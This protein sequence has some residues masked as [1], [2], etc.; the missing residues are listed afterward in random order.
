MIPRILAKYA[1]AIFTKYPVVTITGPRQSGKTTLAKATFADRPYANLENPVTRLFAQEDPLAFLNQYP[2]GAV[3]D[4]IQRAPNLLSYIQVIVDER[5][6]N[7]LYV[8]TGSQQ[9]EFMRGI[10][11]SLAG[12]TA[13]LKLLPLSIPELSGRFSPGIDEMLF[14]GFYPRIYDQDIE[15]AQAYGDY[16]ET[17]VERDLRQL[18]NVKDLSVFQ[19]FVRLCAGRCGQLLNLNS[20]AND[21]GIS[22]S[23][24]REWMTVLEASYIVFLLPPFHANIGKR[25][26][27]SPKI[28]FYDVGLA[29]WLCGIEE[30]KQVA[31]HPLRGSLFENMAIM[32][33]LKHRY[34]LGKRN[35]LYFYRDSNGNEIDLIYTKGPDLLPIEI[36]SGQ[37]ITPAYFSSLKKFYALFPEHLLRPGFLLYGGETEQQRQDAKVM[38][39]FSFPQHLDEIE[40][41]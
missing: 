6:K 37:T 28:Y 30:E 11:Q 13:L 20:L 41:Q 24:A 15:P 27:K 38:R 31:T 26:I 25:L 33:A 40:K 35:N 1:T 10:S 32:E 34:N 36:K 5:R 14:K 8:L 22:Q 18:V 21:T 4:E 9:F 39:I 19:R 16:F 12:R 7:S 2:E 23:T 29:S 3:I 17:Y